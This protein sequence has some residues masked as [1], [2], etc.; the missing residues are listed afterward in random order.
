MSHSK[1]IRPL[2]TAHG[3]PKTRREFLSYGLVPFAASLFLPNPFKWLQGPSFLE[4]AWGSPACP[5]SEGHQWIPFV[6]IDL[7]G[8]AALMANFVP[9]DAQGSLL[10]SYSLMGLE[11]LPALFV[12]LEGLLFI[13]EVA[14]SSEYRP[15]PQRLLAPSCEVFLFACKVAMIEVQIYSP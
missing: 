15:E 13:R 1:K 12:S 9:M 3:K 11:E 2:Q 8:G 7:A 5:N 10:P 14:Y 4:G 6:Q